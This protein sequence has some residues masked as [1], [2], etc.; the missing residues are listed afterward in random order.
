VE[1]PTG[2]GHM[3]TLWEIATDLSRRLTSL[4]ARDAKGCRPAFGGSERLQRDPLWRDYLLF[5]EYFN[6]DDGAGLGASH[7]T[8]WTAVV[9][10]LIQQMG[11]YGA[12]GKMPD[13]TARALGESPEDGG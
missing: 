11:E 2:S 5:N 10:K 6:G 1:Y 12:S 9:A 4:F 7:Q 13:P 8:G 3:A